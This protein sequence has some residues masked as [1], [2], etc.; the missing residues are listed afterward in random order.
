MEGGDPMEKIVPRHVCAFRDDDSMI[1]DWVWNRF[2]FPD[3][4]EAARRTIQAMNILQVHLCPV[5]SP[6]RL[7][8]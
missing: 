8:C 4:A 2:R 7:Y 5:V 1:I 3:G 6:T